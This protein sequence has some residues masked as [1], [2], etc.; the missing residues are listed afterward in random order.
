M[1]L[2]QRLARTFIALTS[3]TLLG[4]FGTALFLV[5]RDETLDLDLTLAREG[6]A[7]AAVE[8]VEDG[9]S[10]PEAH[11][12]LRRYIALYD[13][14]A[15]TLLRATRSFAEPPPSLDWLERA[16]TVEPDG[17][18][19][20]FESGP[21][22]LRGILVRTPSGH[23][24]L[25]ALSRA[26]IVSDV[27][28]LAEVF[29]ALFSIAL[30]LTLAVA[31]ILGERLSRDVDALVQVARRV[32][33]G[34]LS[35]RVAPGVR[36]STEMSLLAES[37]NGMIARLDELVAGQRTFIAH[38]AHEL[39]SPLTT[40][41]GELQLALRRPREA[42]EYRTT[43]EAILVDVEQMTGLAESLLTL[44]RVRKE[45]QE[46]E[47]VEAIA[48]VEEAVRMARGPA[49]QRQV[50]LAVEPSE[51]PEVQLLV[52]RGSV[53]RALRNL[54]DNAVAHSPEGATVRITIQSAQTRVLFHVTDEGRGVSAEEARHLFTPFFRG[55][56]ERAGTGVGLGLAIVREIIEAH[57]GEARVDPDHRPGARFTLELPRHS[58][59]LVPAM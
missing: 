54:I 36:T 4:C 21:E 23:T 10:G 33:T 34:E 5:W 29:S 48:L 12:G 35:A 24:L 26:S 15:R 28:F 49:A 1:K 11:H 40:L 7:A 53:A 51:G 17:D 43:L 55:A 39:R 37:L 16:H 46:R 31:R 19:V 50:Q 56:D 59:P 27:R 18:Y 2:R 25:F 13:G 44:A 38:A 42:S 32:S 9:L 45:T 30:L 47:R 22:A 58:D 6:G 41:R 14:S 57:G 20:D 8:V 52:E 3:V